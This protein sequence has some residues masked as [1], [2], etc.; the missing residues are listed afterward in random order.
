MR[1]DLKTIR[2]IKSRFKK[3]IRSITTWAMSILNALN[4]F[5]V[6]EVITANYVCLR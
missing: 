5:S 6:N 3:K 2:N 4:E 1:Y